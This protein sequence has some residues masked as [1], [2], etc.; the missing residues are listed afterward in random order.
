M[1]IVSSYK[2]QILNNNSI[3]RDTICIY[4]NALSFLIGAFNSEWV[5]CMESRKRRNVSM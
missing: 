3:F 2:V 1:K 5:P 4:R